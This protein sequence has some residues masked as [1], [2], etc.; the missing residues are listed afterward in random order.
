MAA[1]AENRAFVRCVRNFLRIA[2]VGKEEL[3]GS[4]NINASLQQGDQALNQSDP[5]TLLQELMKK[6]NVSFDTLKSKLD[7]E[8]YD[9]SKVNS[10]ND[11][12][13]IKVFELI[14]RLQAAKPKKR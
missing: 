13:K 6:K 8:N 12:P 11:L 1:C 14:E 2:I 7:S 10:L 4:N 3:S 9:I 5:K